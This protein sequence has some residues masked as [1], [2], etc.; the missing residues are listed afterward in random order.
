M[1]TQVRISRMKIYPTPGRNYRVAWKW[2]YTV[3]V[4]KEEFTGDGL[5]WAKRLAQQKSPSGKYVLSW[6][7]RGG[8]S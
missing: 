6:S 5:G 7:T 2:V 8:L 1:E 4:G 3:H